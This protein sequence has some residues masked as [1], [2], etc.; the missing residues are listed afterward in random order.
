MIFEGLEEQQ[1][2]M[3]LEVYEHSGRMEEIIPDEGKGTR[4][5]IAVSKYKA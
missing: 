4:K 1:F 2:K 5:D 3:D